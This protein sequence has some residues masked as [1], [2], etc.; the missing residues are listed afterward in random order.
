V[1]TEYG[2]VGHDVS[3]AVSAQN[4]SIRPRELGLYFLKLAGIEDVVILGRK[5]RG[6]L[7]LQSLD[8]FIR[9]GK[10]GVCASDLI[11]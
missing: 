6:N 8:A 10:I 1:S 5:Q 2:T 7:L 11:M 3:G 4:G 9:G